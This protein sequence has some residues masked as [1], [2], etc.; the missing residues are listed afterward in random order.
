M[1]ILFIILISS[2][3]CS[4]Q[5]ILADTNFVC[6]GQTLQLRVNPKLFLPNDFCVQSEG[7]RNGLYYYSSCNQVSFD[8]AFAFSKIMK[9]HLATVND[10]ELNRFVGRMRGIYIKWLGYVQDEN[11]ESFNDPPN[12]GSGFVWLSG[13]KPG[14]TNWAAEEP[15]NL[16]N[17]EPGKNVILGCSNVN[18]PEWCDVDKNDGHKYIAIIETKESTIPSFPTVSILW[19]NGSTQ[20]EISVIPTETTYY[21]AQIT[22][23]GVVYR[24]SIKISVPEVKVNF[25]NYGGCGD[26]F[27]WQPELISNVPVSDLNLSWQFG[28]NTVQNNEPKPSL[29]TLETGLLALGVKAESKS[30]AAVINDTLTYVDFQY[31]FDTATL[32]E[33]EL[34]LNEIFELSPLNNQPKFIYQWSP[35]TGLSDPNIAKPTFMAENAITYI[36][37]IDDGFGCTTEEVFS[38]TIDPNIIIY[39]PDAFSPNNDQQNDIYKIITNTGFY[40]QLKKFTVYNRWSQK[41]YET[42]TD[43][44][45][46]GEFKQ[47]PV[48]SGVYSFVLNYEIEKVPYTRKGKIVVIR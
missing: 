31:P 7:E 44:Q 36:L 14:Y 21:G 15:D 16:E 8:D 10:A 47:K 3:L 37:K 42:T 5:L 9:G 41:V 24:D 25:E 32:Y 30:C 22:I 2:T 29:S 18:P 40:G 1:R 34:K 38:F 26:P 4:A 28:S 35:S 19:D 6:K 48:A 46:N 17:K 27:Y 11:A 39:M 33:K 12:A 13:T 20:R 45:W 43:W 23:N